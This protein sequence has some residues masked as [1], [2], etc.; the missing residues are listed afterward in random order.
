VTPGC[1]VCR[2]NAYT[3]QGTTAGAHPQDLLFSC[4]QYHTTECIHD[5]TNNG[6]DYMSA[7]T[8]FNI[9]AGLSPQKAGY[10]QHT[11][12]SAANLR[13]QDI[14]QQ[15]VRPAARN[16]QRANASS[17]CVRALTLRALPGVAQASGNVNSNIGF[18]IRIPFTV[19]VAVRLPSLRPL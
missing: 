10:C 2:G 7:L 4:V 16:H 13:N 5:V 15:P 6:G 11:L 3:Q 19:N 14:C 8:Q 1:Q 17:C 9:C 18:H 12:T